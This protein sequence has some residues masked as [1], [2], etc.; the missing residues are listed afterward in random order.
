MSIKRSTFGRWFRSL[1]SVAAA[2]FATSAWANPPNGILDD[3]H[4]NVRAVMAVQGEVTPGWMNL[5][6]VL[7]TAVGLDNND[8][9][10]L[11][12]LVDKD[13]GSV[14]DVIKMLPPQVRGVG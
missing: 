14:A 12:V 4:A 11:V 5:N 9:V 6:G 1:L 10:S 13:N 7:G 2:L 8:Q 3:T